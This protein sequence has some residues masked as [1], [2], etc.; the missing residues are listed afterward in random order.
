MSRQSFW[1]GD[2]CLGSREIN[3]YT[4]Q[5]MDGSLQVA[6]SWGLCC[7]PCQAIWAKV[8]NEHPGTYFQVMS[9]RCPE[10]ARGVEDGVFSSRSSR[11]AI[12]PV[13]HDWPEGAIRHDFTTLLR[14][15]EHNLPQLK[16]I[17]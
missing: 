3:S 5:S 10:H 2:T 7:S 4:T 15:A 17:A 9:R 16:E 1:L 14:S 12:L 8:I 13:E 11:F 6:N